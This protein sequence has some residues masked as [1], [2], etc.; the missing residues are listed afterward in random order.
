MVQTLPG[1]VSEAEPETMA[2]LYLLLGEA[3][4]EAGAINDA[5]RQLEQATRLLP[6]TDPQRGEAL[7]LLAK[8]EETTRQ[9]PDEARTEAKQKYASVISK[10]PGTPAVLPALLGL[11]EIEAATGDFDASAAA[12]SVLIKELATGLKHRDVRTEVVAASL[13]DRFSGRFDSG[14]IDNALKFASLAETAFSAASVPPD[15]LL[16][17]ARSQRRLAQDKLATVK[18][19]SKILDLSHLDPA[20]REQARLELVAAGQYFRRH[21]ERVGVT[22][23]DAYGS[24]LWMAAESF[25]LAGDPDQAIPLYLDY[26]KFFPNEPRQPEARFRLA[27]AYAAKGDYGMSAE[28]Y[29]GLKEEGRSA[30]NKVGPF[31]DASYVPLAKTLLSDGDPSNDSEAEQ[32]LEQVV[33]GLVGEPTTPQFRDALV[34]LAALRRVRGDHTGAAGLRQ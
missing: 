12:Y 10:Y 30:A 22:D 19:E 16:A 23:N 5:S 11:A 1:L 24:S 31:G 33:K 7:V 14:D 8:I 28:Y 29:R 2:E 13:L 17:I 26:V 3:Y 27:Q 20:T 32:L 9:P 6:E 4:W 18:S 25:D 15:I 21:A 34:E